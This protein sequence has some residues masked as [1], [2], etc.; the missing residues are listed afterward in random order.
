MTL[1]YVNRFVQCIY[2]LCDLYRYSFS[3]SIIYKSNRT[4]IS[5]H[6]NTS[7]CADTWTNGC[8]NKRKTGCAD[9]P[10]KW[11]CWQMKK[12]NVPTTEK[13]GWA[14]NW[15]SE[16]ANKWKSECANKWK[17]EC[18]DKWKSE[19]ANKWT[20]GC[21]NKWKEYVPINVSNKFRISWEIGL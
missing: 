14:D 20:N 4:W 17:S 12:V 11:M 1:W 8:A 9:K 5:T 21:A 6:H 15:K 19:C 18:A 16:C 13:H 2:T 7:E 3:I 10:N